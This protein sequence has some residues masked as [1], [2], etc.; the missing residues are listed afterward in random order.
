MT[1][2]STEEPFIAL[3]GNVPATC[4]G[5]ASAAPLSGTSAGSIAR[6]ILICLSCDACW[7]ACALSP[8]AHRPLQGPCCVA[9]LAALAIGTSANRRGLSAVILLFLA[10][11]SVVD[12]LQVVFLTLH[13]HGQSPH[14]G[15][16]P[17]WFAAIWANFGCVAEFLTI[18]RPYPVIC[19]I[20]GALFGPMAY[21]TGEQLHALTIHGPA[22]CPSH[23]CGL[24]ALSLQWALAFP[25]FVVVA[26]AIF[27][28]SPSP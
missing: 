11:G 23:T 27:E 21:V 1:V 3:E 12:S 26:T 25:L 14:L 16:L 9:V 28:K 17:V 22:W 15:L 24:A 18:F 19:S 10:F 20:L 13:F 8:A 6:A 7:F 2:I 4:P 5:S